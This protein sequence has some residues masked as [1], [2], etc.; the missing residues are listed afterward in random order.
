MPTLALD[1]RQVAYEEVG[2]GEGRPLLCVH[3][4]AGSKEDFVPVLDAFGARRVVAVD[5]PG[6]GASPGADDPA[7][8]SLDR[9]AGWVVRLAE[10]LDLDEFHLLGYSHGGL[11]A[12]RVA[13]RAS[14]RLCS[15]VLM[16]TGMGALREEAGDR[17]VRV[18]VAARD[19]GL[20]AGWEE[21]RRIARERGVAEP[22]P[23]R[24]EFERERFHGLNPHAV[25]GA[26]RNL[27][28]A[29]PLWAFLRGIDI[30]VLVVH[31]VDD[32]AWTPEEQQRLAATTRGARRVVIPAAA[33]AP[34]RE[35]A[36]AFV[37]A[38]TAFLDEAEA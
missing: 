21:S 11:V 17:I 3:G 19:H 23:Q 9:L 1:G 2:D 4:F 15:L 38:V 27:V 14:Q 12:Q 22:D 20:E 30:P 6:H 35:N 28:G 29:A 36:E 10:A 7:E 32:D 16:G 26:A 24:A 18:A 37:D 31:G 5:L 25:V 13:A 33:H 8:Y 34:Q